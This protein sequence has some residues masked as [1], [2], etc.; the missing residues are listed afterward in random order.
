MTYEKKIVENS[1]QSL[2]DEYLGENVHYIP[3]A[4]TKFSDFYEKFKIWLDPNEVRN[5]SKIKVG[6][7]LPTKFPKG[8]LPKEDGQFYIGNMSFDPAI[9]PSNN[10]IV[11]NDKLIEEVP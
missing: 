7:E 6:R 11:K 3:G 4:M 1:N 2:L 9:K 10:L 8:R 5:W